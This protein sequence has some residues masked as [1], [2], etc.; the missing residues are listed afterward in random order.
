MLNFSQMTNILISVISK[1]KTDF[2]KTYLLRVNL[3]NLFFKNRNTISDII[4]STEV[5]YINVNKK[6]ID[7][8][9]NE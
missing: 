8:F 6:I 7:S 9:E 3:F 5:G 4:S 2:I 1:L